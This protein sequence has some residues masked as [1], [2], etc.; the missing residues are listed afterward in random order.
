MDSECDYSPQTAG[1]PA[2]TLAGLNARQLGEE[3]RSRPDLVLGLT[4]D[5]LR[6]LCGVQ[7]SVSRL[8]GDAFEGV[9]SRLTGDGP[10]RVR[11]GF[12][13]KLS[14]LEWLAK[15]AGIARR[16]ERLDVLPYDEGELGRAAAAEDL[17]RKVEKQEAR[18]REAATRLQ[19][20]AEQRRQ[21]AA[22]PHEVDV[23]QVGDEHSPPL[24]PAPPKRQQSS[25]RNGTKGRMAREST[26]TRQD[27]ATAPRASVRLA[28]VHGGSLVI[29]NLFTRCALG[30]IGQRGV[31]A[32]SR[33]VYT[34]DEPLCITRVS[35][36]KPS[37]LVVSYSGQQLAIGELETWSALLKLASPASL[38]GRVSF[39]SRDVLELLHRGTGGTAYKRLREEVYR[40]QGGVVTMRTTL[41]SVKELFK[42]MFPTDP[43]VNDPK[44]AQTEHPIEVSFNLL[45]P[46]STDGSRWS[47]V[48]PRE[49][50]LAFSSQLQMWFRRELYFSMRS[51]TTRRLF[52]FYASHAAP[53]PFTLRE[54]CEFVGSGMSRS[55]DQRQQ[56]ERAHDEMQQVGFIESWSYGPS[57][58]RNISEPV[59][60]VRFSGRGQ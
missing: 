42:Q 44:F 23:V 4:P 12:G 58:S 57:R 28:P 51:D 24:S 8:L 13:K 55:F 10:E 22:E 7:S 46:A 27:P 32:Q 31:A 54:L 6:T 39:W 20:A 1:L 59:F 47:I 15:M 45:G 35:G 33:P 17:R 53:W 34:P 38:G 56:M 16:C 48:V 29:C 30:A 26:G 14:E 21:A 50:A 49:V 41:P 40:L 18:A 37:E 3:L 25:S 60:N 11:Q 2:S 43:V 19:A 36:F 9:A 52:L 5:S